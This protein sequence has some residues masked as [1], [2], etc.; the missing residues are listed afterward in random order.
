MNL[1]LADPASRL[2]FESFSVRKENLPEFRDAM[3]RRGIQVAEVHEQL[4]GDL[5]L[6]YRDLC[7]HP[8]GSGDH[9]R[10]A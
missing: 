2:W 1:F 8:A 9:W 10:R 6:C 7:G 3:S 5:L 4:T